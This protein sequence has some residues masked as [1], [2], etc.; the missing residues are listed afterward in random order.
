M[1]FSFRLLVLG[2]V[3]LE[4]GIW[5][6][7]HNSGFVFVMWV[8]VLPGGYEVFTRMYYYRASG[9]GG[10]AVA[11]A[12]PPL[13]QGT[14]GMQ[15]RGATAHAETRRRKSSAKMSKKHSGVAGNGK[16]CSRSLHCV[17]HL[18]ARRYVF[19]SLCNFFVYVGNWN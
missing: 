4:F 15:K 11:H 9:Q 12:V 14:R 7:S 6:G 13:Q 18:P 8:S 16:I 10:G 1:H 3:S 19:K 5:F 2:F 17:P